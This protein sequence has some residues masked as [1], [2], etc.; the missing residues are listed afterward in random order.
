MI[1]ALEEMPSKC[2][3]IL[4]VLENFGC[5]FVN[6]TWPIRYC[7]F[8]SCIIRRNRVRRILIQVLGLGYLS[9]SI[10]T[11]PHLSAKGLKIDL[12]VEHS[13]QG[14]CRTGI[15]SRSSP[16]KLKQLPDANSM[17]HIIHFKVADNN[18]NNNN[19]KQSILPPSM[20]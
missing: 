13:F 9:K 1:T 19:S 20:R 2:Q 12:V 4:C 11:F 5:V 6:D 7:A 15:G 14:N 10:K 3:S 16:E 17:C 18:N 8:V